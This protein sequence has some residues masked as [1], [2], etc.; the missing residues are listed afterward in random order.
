MDDPRASVHSLTRRAKDKTVFGQP[1]KAVPG[2]IA[3][4]MRP[5]EAF[6][7]TLLDCLAQITANAATLRLGRSVEGL[8]QLRVAFRRLEVALG[9]FGREFGQEW[10]EE[11]RGRAKILLGRLSPA[12]DLD[13]FTSKL[14][15]SPPKSGVSEGLPQL[16]ARAESARDT[17]WVAAMACIGS[18]DF[19]MFTDDVAAL[20]GS[21]LPLTRDRKLKRTAR[22]IL[23]R[24]NR[25]VKRRAKAAKSEKEGDLHR[26]RIAL[27]KLRYTAEFFAPLYPRRAA[28]RYLKEVRGLQNHLGDLNDVANVRSVVGGLIRERTRKDEDTAMRYAAGAMVGW[29]GAQVPHAVSHALKCYKKFKKVELFWG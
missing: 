10:I 29:Y 14:L 23:N 2:Y 13:V 15:A 26:L 5:E 9:A 20:A 7:A 12:R 8:H 21:Q 11:L 6:R 25:R 3:K 27:K 24:Q 18:D 28:E 4:S 17:A 16:R 22:R 19:E 1:V